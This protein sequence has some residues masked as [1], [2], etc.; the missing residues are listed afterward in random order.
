M[1]DM[2]ERRFSESRR[3][4]RCSWVGGV[5]TQGSFRSVQRS[6]FAPEV[7]MHLRF[8]SRQVSHCKILDLREEKIVVPT[9]GHLDSITGWH[10]AGQ[11]PVDAASALASRCQ[12]AV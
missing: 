9:H 7:G 2:L 8:R 5:M 1:F 10:N 12:F 3:T 11:A 4:L 6:H